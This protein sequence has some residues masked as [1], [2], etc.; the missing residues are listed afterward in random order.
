MTTPSDLL[1]KPA[2][3]HPGAS[4]LT[5]REL[6]AIELM[7]GLLAAP[8]DQFTADANASIPMRTWAQYAK[9]A[10]QA[11]NALAAAL[12]KETNP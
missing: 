9:G 12:A 1:S 10:V 2:F 8:A 3:P 6:A 4:G 5:F 7:K 11:V